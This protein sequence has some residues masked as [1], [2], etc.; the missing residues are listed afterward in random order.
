MIKDYL[1]KKD[2]L[3]QDLIKFVC[4]AQPVSLRPCNITLPIGS[5][6]VSFW[7]KPIQSEEASDL[8]N[9]ILVLTYSIRSGKLYL[10]ILLLGLVI[11]DH[12]MERMPVL[13]QRAILSEK[14][15]NKRITRFNSSEWIGYFNARVRFLR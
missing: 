9:P 3:E 6:R 14:G 13:S 8:D 11:I 10:V 12:V 2:I 4:K 1:T 15:S 5:A 7:W